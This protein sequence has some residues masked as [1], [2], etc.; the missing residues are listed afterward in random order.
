MKLFYNT[1]SPYSRKCR[2]VILEKG[3][4][5]KVELVESLPPHLSE[6]LLAANPLARIPALVM[7]DGRLLCESPVIC[8]YLDGV[9][10]QNSLFPADKEARIEALCL[11]ALGSGIMD[12]A[13]ACVMEGRRPEEKRYAE[14]VERKE[15]AIR[16]TITVLAAEN[17]G[18]E[19]HIGAL[20]VAVAL[21]YIDFRLPHIDWRNEHKKLAAWLKTTEKRASMLA[22]APITA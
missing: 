21:A 3:L 7:D 20:S 19:F 15:N 9:S 10:V 22:T 18:D 17:L 4:Q 2:I 5:D 13:V 6:A 14:W 12:S 8:E 11:A 1:N 16:R